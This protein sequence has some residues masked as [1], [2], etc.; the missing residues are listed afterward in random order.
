VPHSYRGCS[1]HAPDEHVLKPVCRDALRLMAGLF[2]DIG[3]GGTPTR[4]GG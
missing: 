3:E 1:Q 2:W 4:Q